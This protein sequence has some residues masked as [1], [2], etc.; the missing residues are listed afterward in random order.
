MPEDLDRYYTPPALARALVQ[1]LADQHWGEPPDVLEPHAGGCAFLDALEEHGCTVIAADVD[2]HSLAVVQ[3]G[4]LCREFLQEW[5]PKCP[6]P[7]WIV[8]NPPYGEAEEHTR[9]ALRT[10]TIGV[11]FL[12]RLGMLE[13]RKRIPFWRGPGSCLEAVHVLAQR[14][15]FVSSVTRTGA[16]DSA[17]YGW[18]VWRHGYSGPARIVPG[19]SWR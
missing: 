16:T 1:V 13:S 8:G 3:A 5:D 7:S 11:A 4:A 15:S 12:L 2:P 19:L 17:A 6:R 18:F 10:A 9:H 14:P